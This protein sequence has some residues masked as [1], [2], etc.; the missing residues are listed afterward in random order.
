MDQT[1]Y[2]VT[3]SD[4]DDYEIVGGLFFMDRDSAE[5]YLK[6]QPLRRY[7]LEIE[8]FTLKGNDASTD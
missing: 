6:K 4:W 3:Y 7:L 5:D 2:A 8:E 1:I